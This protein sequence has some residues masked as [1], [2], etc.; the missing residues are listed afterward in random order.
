MGKGKK[1]VAIQR[2]SPKALRAVAFH[3][4][5]HV[6]ARAFTKLEMGHIRQVSIVA[7]ARTWGHERSERALT[8]FTLHI[9][10]KDLAWRDG[11]ML[12]LGLLA[13]SAAGEKI[14]SRSLSS[15]SG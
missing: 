12:L 1:K 11:R 14:D 15:H 7:N 6:A 3:E 2:L 8:L 9:Q 4:A 10:P 5:G 13:G